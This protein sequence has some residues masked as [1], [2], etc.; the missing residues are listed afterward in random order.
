MNVSKQNKQFGFRSI[1]VRVI[2]KNQHKS[3]NA[4]DNTTVV[5]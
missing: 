3:L 2:I 1:I 4:L 5:L